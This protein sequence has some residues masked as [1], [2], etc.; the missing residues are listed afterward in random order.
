MTF[1]TPPR[2]SGRHWRG[3]EDPTRIRA[4]FVEPHPSDTEMQPP[5][6]LGERRDVGEERRRIYRSARDAARYQDLVVPR[7]FVEPDEQMDNL[8]RSA[9]RWGR[10]RDA[11]V[12]AVGLY[13]LG[14]WCLP[15]LWA[16]LGG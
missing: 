13:L 10:W 6:N 15:P 5:M 9:I 14:S 3:D 7:V 11:V 8:R 12:I 2:G 1:P 16:L 4:P